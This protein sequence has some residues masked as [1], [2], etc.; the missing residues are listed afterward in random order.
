MSVIFLQKSQSEK[1]VSNFSAEK[2]TRK[3]R[4]YIKKITAYTVFEELY[5]QNQNKL[6]NSEQGSRQGEQIL[7]FWSRSLFRRGGK[8][9]VTK[10]VSIIKGKWQKLYQA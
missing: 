6:V 2:S 8:L 9:Q 10:V 7:S 4:S 3:Q 1:N 5:V